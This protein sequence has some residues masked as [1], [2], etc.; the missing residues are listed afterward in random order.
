MKIGQLQSNFPTEKSELHS[1]FTT[2]TFT[3][4]TEMRM[5]DCFLQ[6]KT[7]N[8]EAQTV[9]QCLHSVARQVSYIAGLCFVGKQKKL[10][11]WFTNQSLPMILS[12]TD[13]SQWLQ[14]ISQQGLSVSPHYNSRVL[15]SFLMRFKIQHR[16]CISM[17]DWRIHFALKKGEVGRQTSQQWIIWTKRKRML[18]I[19]CQ[20]SNLKMGDLLKLLPEK[21]EIK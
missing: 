18:L 1:K 17:K 6:H 15:M 14:I 2:V 9:I 10:F 4:C 8:L 21:T 16:Y 13:P 12:T 11:Y 19:H 7:S 20:K 5:K 3:K